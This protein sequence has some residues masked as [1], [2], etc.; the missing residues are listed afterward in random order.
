LGV[1]EERLD[2][3]KLMIAPVSNGEMGAMMAGFEACR[4]R[5]VV[6]GK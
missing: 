1:E 6:L 3:E 4:S 5:K 2:V